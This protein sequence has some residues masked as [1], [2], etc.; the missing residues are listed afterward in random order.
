MDGMNGREARMLDAQAAIIG[1]ILIKPEISAEVFAS[2]KAE[3][4]TIPQFRRL[5]EACREIH[6][7][8]NMPDA[9]MLVGKVGD[10]YR[11]T[12]VDCAAVTPSASRWKSYAAQLREDSTLSRI[13]DLGMQLT[14]AENSDEA[15]EIIRQAAELFDRRTE[16][17]T[18]T[19]EAG[20]EDLIRRMK[21]HSPP[22]YIKTGL[23]DLDSGIFA[24]A[25]D[26]ILLGGY[27]SSGKTAL[28]LQMA[29]N[30]SR[31]HNVG[32]FS[33][34]TSPEKLMDR[35]AACFAQVNFAEVKKR[36][37]RDVEIER[38]ERSAEIIRKQNCRLSFEQA[39]RMTVQELESVTMAKGYDVILID[40]IQLLS[41]GGRDRTRYESTTEVSMELHK[42]AQDRKVCIIA[43]SQLSRPDKSAG[44]NPR[45]PSMSDLR[46]SGQLEQD[47]DIIMLLSSDSTDPNS[48][49]R[50]LQVP[51]NKEGRK[52]IMYLRFDGAHQYFY[53]NGK[54]KE[55][56]DD[57][58]G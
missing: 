52:G 56:T 11:Q 29:L 34:E 53:P 46:E 35:A 10:A 47:A 32:F 40:Y 15:A 6:R 2:V 16:N 51:K 24:A 57:Q 36:S 12:I 22:Q 9:I 50:V 37:L 21:D 1:S 26:Y 8:G 54:A 20:M 17:R 44:K 7:D 49:E 30:L 33:L 19:L 55:N 48:Q 27:P 38:I 58:A 41:S 42:F 13:R 45:R 25:G 28:A 18:I 4:F 43:L 5:Y 31:S 3:D 23:K 39:S 14:G